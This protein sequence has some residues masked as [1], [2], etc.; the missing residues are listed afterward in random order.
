MKEKIKPKVRKTH[1]QLLQDVMDAIGMLFADMSVT[2]STTRESLEEIRDAA[3]ER[4]DAL[5]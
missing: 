1:E 5:P 2:A 3:Q 4:I